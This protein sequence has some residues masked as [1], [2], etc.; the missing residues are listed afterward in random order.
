MFVLGEYLGYQKRDYSPSANKKK[1]PPDRG[2]RG[3]FL[4]GC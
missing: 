4:V 1:K 2:A 3:L